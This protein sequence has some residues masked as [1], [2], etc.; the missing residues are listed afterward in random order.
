VTLSY[1]PQ[2]GQLAAAD[3]FFCTNFLVCNTDEIQVLAQPNLLAPV[4]LSVVRDRTNRMISPS[5]GYTLAAELELAAKA[6]A[7]DFDYQRLL[8]EA[9]LYRGLVGETVLA[10]R[11]RGGWIGASAFRGFDRTVQEGIR[12]SPP[13]KRF[14]AGGA[15]S[16]RGYPQNQLGPRVVTVG[17]EE[18]LPIC[19]PQS[20]ANLTCDASPLAEG[21]FASRPT[22]GS[23]V[24]E[25][26]LELRFPVWGPFVTGAAF[27]DFGQVWAR[28]DEVRLG[29][30]VITPGVGLRYSTPIGPLRLDLAYRPRARQPFPVV[31]SA[32][33]PWDADRDPESAR[34]LDPVSGEPIDWVLLDALARLGPRVSFAESAGFTL[35]RVQLQL[36]I[37]Q[38]F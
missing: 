29:E 28:N 6:T 15:N 22:G 10:A 25:G 7:S 34:I 11:L 17:V 36:S 26:G 33:R 23:T 4:G 24:L 13:Q 2:L 5:G 37:G 8:A 27:A 21:D 32:I 31:T 14:Y 12:I 20:L 3:V 19:T 16:V 18:L 35:R 1:Q 9:T 38:A 30:M